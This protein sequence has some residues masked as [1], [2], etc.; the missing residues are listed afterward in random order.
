MSIPTPDTSQSYD[1]WAVESIELSP[2]IV[3]IGDNLTG[4]YHPDML[5][6]LLTT[7]ALFEQFS[8]NENA[9]MDIE[10]AILINERNVDLGVGEDDDLVEAL[11]IIVD[12]Y[13]ETVFEHTGIF[14]IESLPLYKKNKLI[15]LLLDL[16]NMEPD[17]H[18]T[19]L[20]L[21]NTDAIEKFANVLGY[22]T[23]KDPAEFILLFDYVDPKLLITLERLN[24][25]LNTESGIDPNQIKRL[26]KLRMV[27][28]D[29]VLLGYDL[30]VA[31]VKPGQSFDVYYLMA[32]EFIATLRKQSNLE[33]L[34]TTFLSL[35]LL[36]D[37]DLKQAV[38]IAQT[39]TR[40]ILK[41]EAIKINIAIANLASQITI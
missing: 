11:R 3:N 8:Y 31:G 13:A 33:G 5:A 9:F 37:G 41:E 24:A 23:G 1:F 26:K 10:Q 4:L 2:F 40:G 34:A 15:A 18:I 14:C 25:T 29:E 22:L 19:Y 38:N 16:Q 12:D 30:L 27:V 20:C 28:S 35:A 7:L 32:D 39:A 17:E 21:A 6:S 36:V